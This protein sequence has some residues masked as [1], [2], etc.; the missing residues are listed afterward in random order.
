MT[1]HAAKLGQLVDRFRSVRMVVAGDLI[2]DEFIYGRIDRVSREAPVLILKYDS[3]EIVPGGAGNAANNAAALGARVVIVG[4]AGRDEAGT[5]MMHVLGGSSN[6][7]SIVRP[8]G[9]ATP[10]P[11]RGCGSAR[12]SRSSERPEPPRRAG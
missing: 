1:R 2:A 8:G 6:V 9:Y 3:T 11:R 4:V 10:W 7:K 12:S 5:R